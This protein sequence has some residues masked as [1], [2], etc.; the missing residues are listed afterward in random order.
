MIRQELREPALSIAPQT[1]LLDLDLWDSIKTIG[2][3]LAVEERFGFTIS[4]RDVDGIERVEDVLRV[5]DAALAEAAVR[6]G[7]AVP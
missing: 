4:A 3:I 2:L 1:R 7:T 6:A 5:I